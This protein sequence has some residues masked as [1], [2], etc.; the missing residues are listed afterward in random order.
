MKGLGDAIAALPDLAIIVERDGSSVHANAQAE[1]LFGCG[2]ASW[3][4]RIWGFHPARALEAPRD[5][6]PPLQSQEAARQ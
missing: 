4:S 5:L 1:R 2:Q 3:E 6:E